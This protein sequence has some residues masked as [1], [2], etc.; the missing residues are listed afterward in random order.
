V[1]NT[2]VPE[3]WVIPKHGLHKGRLALVLTKRKFLVAPVS[4]S[5]TVGLGLMVHQQYHKCIE[6]SQAT[7]LLRKSFTPVQHPTPD[8]LAAF[9]V[10][11]HPALQKFVLEGIAQLSPKAIVWLW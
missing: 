11:D 10:D 9:L 3:T 7:D 1:D 4:L 5:E 6:V 2:L 8:Q